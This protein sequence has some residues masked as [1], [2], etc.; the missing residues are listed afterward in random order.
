M[1]RLKTFLGPFARRGF[2]SRSLRIHR[3]GEPYASYLQRQKTKTTDPERIKK[4]QTEEWGTKIEG[5]RRIFERHEGILSPGEKALCLGSRTGQEVVALQERGISAIGIDLVPFP[6][7]TV[8]GD[9]HDLNYQEASVDIVFTNVFDHTPQPNLFIDE[10]ERVL[11][12]G[13]YA[14]VQLQLATR[15]DS[16]SE[17]DVVN[18]KSVLNLFRQSTCV[19]SHKIR[20][21]HDSMDWELVMRRNERKGAPIDISTT[22]AGCHK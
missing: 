15:G 2:G 10:I 19:A 12:G 11:R 1:R 9:F 6:P 18:A 20:N 5:F 16:F 8:E 4:W 3:P 7:Y 21:A 17:N 14:I 22:N 13:G